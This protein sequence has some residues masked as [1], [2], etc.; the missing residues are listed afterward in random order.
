[1]TIEIITLK[2]LHIDYADRAA[3]RRQRAAVERERH[4]KNGAPED[5]SAALAL[6]LR[7]TRTEAAGKLYLNPVTWHAFKD[8]IHNLP[9]LEDWIDVKGVPYDRDSLIVQKDDPEHW[10]YLLVSAQNHP[11]YKIIGWCWGHEAKQKRFLFDP[12]GGREAHFVRQRYGILKPPL[13]L[14]HEVRRRQLRRAR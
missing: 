2:T 1:M 5:Y 3:N 11:Q 6:H 8:S 14:F 13:E 10:A 9:D 4:A 7:G 12:V